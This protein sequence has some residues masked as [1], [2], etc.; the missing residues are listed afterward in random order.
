[1]DVQ[2]DG[3]VFAETPCPG[4]F[5]TRHTRSL[6]QLHDVVN[7]EWPIPTLSGSILGLRTRTQRNFSRGKGGKRSHDC[8]CQLD[9]T[10]STG[11]AGFGQSQICQSR[12]PARSEREYQHMFHNQET[13]I[14]LLRGRQFLRYKPTESFSLPRLDVSFSVTSVAPFW[15]SCEGHVYRPGFHEAQ[16]QPNGGSDIAPET[17]SRDG[18]PSGGEAGCP[19]RRQDE[20]LGKG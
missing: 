6:R 14:S 13:N 10:L 12:R 1:M 17:R 18:P 15:A 5:D 9:P 11:M 8:H 7:I 2:L 4:V 19:R 3:P 16:E 20:L